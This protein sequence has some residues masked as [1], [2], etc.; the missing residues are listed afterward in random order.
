[1]LL[2]AFGPRPPFPE[3]RADAPCDLIF[4]LEALPPPGRAFVFVPIQHG[5]TSPRSARRP[6]ESAQRIGEPFAEGL[7]IFHH[8]SHHTLGVR[9]G[10]FRQTATYLRYRGRSKKSEAASPSPPIRGCTRYLGSAPPLLTP[11]VRPSM[12]SPSEPCR[13]P[14]RAFVF[15][16]PSPPYPPQSTSFGGPARGPWGASGALRK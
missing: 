7:R 2:V 16:A 5:T 10:G 9:T 3:A 13:P 15:P 11:G 14:G 4:S 8:P 6:P 12:V 1:V